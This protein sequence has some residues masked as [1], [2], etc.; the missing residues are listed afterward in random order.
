MKKSMR[1]VADNYKGYSVFK[2]KWLYYAVSD[3]LSKNSESERIFAS[4]IAE[5]NKKMVSP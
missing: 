5:L 4:S 2:A 1:K 3:C